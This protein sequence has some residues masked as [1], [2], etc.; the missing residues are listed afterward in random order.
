MMRDD[1]VGRRRVFAWAL[2]ASLALHSLLAA[3]LIFGAPASL[4]RPQKEEAIAVELVP[5]PKPPD[6]ARA[7][8]AEP[9][10][11]KPNQAKDE[12][13]PS[14]DRDPTA[15]S[16]V[17]KP[18]FQFGEKDAGPK[19]SPKGNS[20]RAKPREAEAGSS[21]GSGN[22]REAAGQ[23]GEARKDAVDGSAAPHRPDS[24]EPAR[25]PSLVAVEALTRVPGP[26]AHETPAPKAAVGA[27][28]ASLL[29]E[30]KTLFSR[31]ATGNR[32]A[33]TAMGKLPRSARV[34]QLCASELAEQLRHAWPPLFPEFV[35][36]IHLNDGTILDVPEAA[37]RANRRWYDLS[38]RCEV[39][40]DA[41]K[42]VSFAFR[43]GDPIPK[44][45][46]KRRGLPAG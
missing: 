45:E 22:N 35:P 27:G 25:P 40:T 5:P 9:N 44:N 12:K 14:P 11:E 18:V 37:F 16:P 13:P 3:Y 30:A 1:F 42:V 31:N 10:S 32:M 38:Y 19:A 33:T 28:R 39:D 15:P 21:S 2:S 29:E 8:P 23:T 26:V 43:V 24:Q 36:D 34:S 41:T 46:W 4:P 17:L 7:E 6:K 20:A